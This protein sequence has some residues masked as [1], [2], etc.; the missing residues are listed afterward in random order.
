MKKT[1]KFGFLYCV[2]YVISKCTVT[3]YLL[4]TKLKRAYDNLPYRLK[5]H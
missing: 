5:Y 2:Y 1:S 4:G 3:V